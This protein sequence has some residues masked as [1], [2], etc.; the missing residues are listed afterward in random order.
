MKFISESTIDEA[1]EV[2]NEP[3]VSD[4]LL[5]QMAISQPT[6][7]AYITAENA[8]A[9]S[10]SEKDFLYFA[11]LVIL[12]SIK[13]EVDDLPDL[14]VSMID[15]IEERNYSMLMETK[16]KVFRDR[17]TVFFENYTQE[18]LLAFVEDALEEDE[19]ALITKEGRDYLFVM[20]KTIIDTFDASIV[21]E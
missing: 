16:G 2:L 11:T 14:K 5:K 21:N 1:I 10:D 19:D 15:Q 3:S 13:K 9:F 12:L 8:S 17:I 20:L 4:A 18:D 7:L 6:L